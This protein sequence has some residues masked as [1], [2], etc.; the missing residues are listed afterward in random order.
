MYKKKIIVISII[1]LLIMA[2]ILTIYFI[3][4]QP[5]ATEAELEKIY[6]V[7]TYDNPIIPNGFRKVETDNASWK[8]D[9]NQKIT[10]WN[11]G[12]V[13]EDE[14][15]NQF[16]WI[17]VADKYKDKEYIVSDDE[18]EIQLFKYGGFYISRYEAGVPEQL[19]GQLNNI[20]SETND[21]KGIPVSK[22]NI[23]PWNYISYNN[24][25]ESAKLM[26]NSKYVKSELMSINKSKIIVEWLENSGYNISDSSSWGNFSNS[27]YNFSGLYSSD[28]GN[29]YQIASNKLKNDN[30]IMGT[31]ITDRNMSNNIYDFAGNL[32]E[33]T[34][35]QFKDTKFH[36]SVGG[37]YSAPGRESSGAPVSE[38]YA[39]ADEPVG[40]TGFRV[41]LIILE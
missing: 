30:M 35:T 29:S 14:I 36:F 15:G 34:N 18:E 7:S 8:V 40:T 1:V 17:P 38:Q 39:Y 26:Y 19:Q 22:K 5:K 3:N 21:I 31:G 24:A 4:K 12:L 11:N 13:I 41:C 28:T 10:G 32:R 2:C 23:R 9:E 33:Y 16:V 25:D 6:R 37:Y 20:S 27:V